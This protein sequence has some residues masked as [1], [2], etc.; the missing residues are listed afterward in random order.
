MKWNTQYEPNNPIGEI[1]NLPSMTIPNE[2][3]SVRE[4]LVRYSRG[5]PIDSKVPMFDEEND[6][7]DPRK[8]DLAD[9][10]T[11]REQYQE[12]L[13]QINE[14]KKKRD[15]EQRKKDEEKAAQEKQFLEDLNE[16]RNQK[17]RQ[18]QQQQQ[19]QIS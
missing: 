19:N 1:N 6:L 15:E 4:I 8:I 11:L 13:E 9:A 7:I 12:E 3:L 17:Q 18:Q 10:Q 16:F 5:M 14:R 2:A